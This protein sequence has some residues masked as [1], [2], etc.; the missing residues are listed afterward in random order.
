M[1][2]NAFLIII[3][4]PPETD[5]PEKDGLFSAIAQEEEHNCLASLNDKN[6]SLLAGSDPAQRCSRL[7]SHRAA[8]SYAEYT[9]NVSVPE[10]YDGNHAI[11]HG[12][13]CVQ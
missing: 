12:N 9:L 8:I 5:N 1:K 10:L 2:Q 13:C 11:W 3:P 4:A 6:A 7:R